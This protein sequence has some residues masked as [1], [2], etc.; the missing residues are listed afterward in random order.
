MISP[1]GLKK[2]KQLYRK[3]FGMEI[4]D[5]TALD[6]GIRLVNLI[7]AVYKPMT[8]AEYENLQKRRKETGDTASKN[9]KK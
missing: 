2:F 3:H 9:E 6:K 5:Q 7:K 4:D 8:E 1:K